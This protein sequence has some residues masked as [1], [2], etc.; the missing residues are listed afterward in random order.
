MWRRVRKSTYL[1]EEITFLMTFIS[2][3]IIIVQSDRNGDVLKRLLRLYYYGE[4]LFIDMKPY[5]ELWQIWRETCQNDN[6][7]LQ[8]IWIRENY[9]AF[10]YTR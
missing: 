9:I 2:R 6:I 1:V 8:W 10:E 5:V 3:L 7:G 4:Q